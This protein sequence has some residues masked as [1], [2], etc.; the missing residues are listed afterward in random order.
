MYNNKYEFGYVDILE[1][2]RK[3]QFL[4]KHNLL[5]VSEEEIE[6]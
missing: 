4:K 5:K 2:R 1:I 6:I 3:G